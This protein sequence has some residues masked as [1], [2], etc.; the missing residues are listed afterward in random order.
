[1]SDDRVIALLA[2]WDRVVNPLWDWYFSGHE[3]PYIPHMRCRYCSA[4]NTPTIEEFVHEDGCIITRTKALLAE[5]G[6]EH[7]A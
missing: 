3:N 1:M 4:P 6:V 7:D 2:E 5:L